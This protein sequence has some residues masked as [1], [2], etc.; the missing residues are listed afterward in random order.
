M[1]P[2]YKRRQVFVNRPVQGRLLLRF[3]GLWGLYHL[4]L[5]HVMFLFRFFQYFRDILNG[6]APQSFGG[7]Y[8]EFAREH[9]LILVCA[10]MV[11]PILLWEVLKLS[12]RFVGPLVQFKRCL[13]HLAR[14]E[15]VT[16]V[17]IRKGDFL[18]DL[19]NSFNEFLRSP[20]APGQ[21]A[22][23]PA[24]PAG[25]PGLAPSVSDDAGRLQADLKNLRAWLKT[26][27]GSVE[28][29]QTSH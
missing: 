15:R 23:S 11:L 27:I 14:G 24:A 28:Q 12:H 25:D 19:Q 26:G 4:V 3:L 17:H 9:Y 29:G 2:R 13:S 1:S 20:Y 21:P 16:E 18:V 5:W 22:A 6:G 10:V 7:L 8:M